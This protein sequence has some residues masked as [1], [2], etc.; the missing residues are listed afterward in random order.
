MTARDCVKRL[1]DSTK[2][3]AYRNPSV[4]DL[5]HKI[6]EEPLIVSAF[7]LLKLIN[8]DDR[9]DLVSPRQQ[10]RYRQLH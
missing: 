8:N 6:C 10:K 9:L 3:E 5:F 7:E 4:V 2:Y 1:A